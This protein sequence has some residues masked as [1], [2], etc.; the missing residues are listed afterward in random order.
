MNN[1]KCIAEL[2]LSLTNPNLSNPVVT[3]GV[4][5]FNQERI[6]VRNLS[7][8]LENTSSN[9]EM[10]IIDD[11]SRD[12]S[13]QAILNVF[14]D[15]IFEDFPNLANVRIYRNTTAKF[16]T[17]CDNLAI[18]ESRS[19]YFIEIQSDM[20]IEQPGYDKKLIEAIT[21]FDDLIAISGRGVH[22]ILD[23]INEYAKTA[24]SD[25]SRGKTILRHVVNVIRARIRTLN[26][27]TVSETQSPQ[28]D[29][30]S[31]SDRP[32][33]ALQ[34]DF[35]ISGATGQLGPLVET[36]V[37]AKYIKARNIFVGESIM[38]GPLLIDLKKLGNLGPWDQGTFFQGF[39]DH[40]FCLRAYVLQGYRVGYVPISFASPSQ[41]GTTR[42]RK[43]LLSEFS[44]LSNLLRI[45]RTR[46]ESQLYLAT[47]NG[48]PNLPA[49]EV[50][51]F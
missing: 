14:N 26:R 16:E 24:G 15:E 1:S 7:S 12:L 44:I 11:A 51:S 18:S 22:K 10:I 3:I 23:V 29:R 47:I 46:K 40:D 48:L 34:K 50:R 6:I 30:T 31:I 19:N 27:D 49:P 9:F 35:L 41:D 4:P 38:R 20:F 43:S 25:R 13:L 42:K 28:S 2:V 8:I 5:V 21:A 32:S 37:E 39:D 33:F 45:R 36:K 17:Y